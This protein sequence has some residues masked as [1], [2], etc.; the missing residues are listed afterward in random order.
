MGLLRKAEEA[1]QR[2]Q[3]KIAEEIEER[4]RKESEQAIKAQHRRMEELTRKAD[5]TMAK[6]EVMRGD[7]DYE[8]YLL[9]KEMLKK[10]G[11]R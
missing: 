7:F 10:Q 1:E 9:G 8:V 3:E 11:K 4:K 6:N 5:K 2:R